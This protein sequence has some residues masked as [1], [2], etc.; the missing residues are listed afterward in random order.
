ME[1]V[2]VDLRTRRTIKAIKGAFS[3]LVLEKN[4]SDI[5]I[6]ELAKRAEINRKTFYLH[7]SSLDDL[8]NDIEREIVET[9]LKS[10]EKELSELNVA[11]CISKF[12][13]YL[14][15]CDDVQKK[16]LC[17]TDYTFF[18]DNV[19]TMLLESKPF[20]A[21]YEKKRHPYVVKAYCVTITSIYKSWLVNGRPT[22]IDEL[23]DYACD[24]ILHG[25][26]GATL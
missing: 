19:T 5:S 14:N 6:T 23:I 4:Y 7:Y 16:L 8:V 18:Y 20:K 22:P 21:F 11:G 13:H 24:L 2:R 1:E 12:Y 15:D 17:D 26:D 25:Y 10:I 9:F 3:Q